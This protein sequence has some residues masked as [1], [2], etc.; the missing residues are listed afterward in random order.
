MLGEFR[1]N[2]LIMIFADKYMTLFFQQTYC[3][4]WERAIAIGDGK[5]LLQATGLY[6]II[7]GTTTAI[8]LA[9]VA[10]PVVVARSKTLP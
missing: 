5:G 6:T 4:I 3:T 8:D 9:Q 10:P 2:V 1:L 7:F